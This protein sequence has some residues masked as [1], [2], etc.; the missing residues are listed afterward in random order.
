[1][2]KVLRF[3][4]FSLIGIVLLASIGMGAFIYKI[5]YGFPRND[6]NPPSLPVATSE[7]SVLV[8]SKTTGYRHGDAI[9]SAVSSFSTIAADRGWEIYATENAAVFTPELLDRFEVVIWNN[10]SGTVL[11]DA[12]R[13]AFRKYIENGGGFIG[14]HAAG[15]FSHPWD[16]YKN[17]LIR[18]DFSH[19]P[20]DPQVQNADLN[21]E[22][23]QSFP[24]DR[25]AKEWNSAD[26]W[27]IFNDNPRKNGSTILYTVDES[28]MNPNGNFLFFRG[29]DWGMGEDHPIAWYQCVGEG[30]AFYSAMGHTAEAFREENHLSMLTK[31]IEWAG[32]REGT[33]P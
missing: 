30:R 29:K 8:F 2:N 33:C 23:N 19:H 18:A 16:W 31:A 6:Q 24:T 10:V 13:V 5:R 27:Y 32:K 7:F 17:E 14:I 22:F 12:Q 21:L 15:D 28:E 26:E 3:V 20:M 9:E 25:L 1:M 11:N 4:L